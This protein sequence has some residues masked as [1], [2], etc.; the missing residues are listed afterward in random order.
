MMQFHSEPGWTGM[1]TRRQAPGALSNGT[2]VEKIA[3]EKNDAHPIGAHATVL[4]SI[5]HPENGMVLYFVEWD[6]KPR[7]AIGVVAWKVRELP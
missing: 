1:F 5:A 6:A 3:T 7:W 4:G 2:R